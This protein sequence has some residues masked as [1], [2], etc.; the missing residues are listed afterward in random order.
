MY[1][2]AIKFIDKD[3][4][5]EKLEDVAIEGIELYSN[6]DILFS[7]IRQN[8]I[9]ALSLTSMTQAQ[10]MSIMSETLN[11]DKKHNFLK[12]TLPKDPLDPDTSLLLDV[13][14]MTDEQF[15]VLSK[16]LSDS[17]QL[18]KLHLIVNQSLPLAHE[19]ALIQV[20]RENF[21]INYVAI[22]GFISEYFMTTMPK[23]SGMNILD[24]SI[25]GV[26]NIQVFIF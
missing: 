20:I 17:R 6:L 16:A 22:S 19:M 8:L 13:G 14:T 25:K 10:S 7:C 21:K 23:R 12:Y 24:L 5:A 18:E 26:N 3:L 9:K 4:S 1:C 15:G 2:F 11:Q